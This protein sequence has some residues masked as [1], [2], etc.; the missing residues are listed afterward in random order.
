MGRLNL[1]D[2]RIE[3]FVREPLS[4]RNAAGVIVVTT[5]LV[6][7]G[8]GILISLIDSEEYP[9]IGIGMWWARRRVRRTS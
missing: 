7:V 6:V 9:N 3:R 2:R 8:A 1:I 5:T 4:V